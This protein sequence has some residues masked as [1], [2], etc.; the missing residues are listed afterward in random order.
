MACAQVSIRASARTAQR[1]G[2]F[3]TLARLLQAV[4]AQVAG[5]ALQQRQR[6]RQPERARR[7]GRSRRK[8]WSCRLLVAV[9]TSA[10][11]PDSSSGTR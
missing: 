10:R 5:A 6:D 4:Q 7:R 3:A 8:S 11:R 2:R 1:S 9:L